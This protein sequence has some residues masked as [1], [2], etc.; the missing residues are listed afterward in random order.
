[1]NII[2]WISRADGSHLKKKFSSNFERILGLCFQAAR[3]NK[4]FIVNLN[5][6][7]GTQY[8]SR[9]IYCCRDN[10]LSLSTSLA[11]SLPLPELLKVYFAVTVGVFLWQIESI[12]P[13]S[14]S[15]LFPKTW[16]IYVWAVAGDHDVE[17]QTHK[18]TKIDTC[19]T[20]V[21]P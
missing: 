12:F 14:F 16:V 11:R 4:L 10:S 9:F 5:I 19:L 17:G 7:R 6:L 15:L 8:L 13:S 1:M 21:L 2:Q 18:H 3:L 20:F